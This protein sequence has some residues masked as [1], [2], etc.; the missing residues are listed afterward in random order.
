MVTAIYLLFSDAVFVRNI[1]IAKSGK[2]SGV[3]SNGSNK[4]SEMIKAAGV[5]FEI[6]Q[7]SGNIVF[8]GK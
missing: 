7:I 4:F 3:V 1:Q 6:K 5:S 8:E 2:I